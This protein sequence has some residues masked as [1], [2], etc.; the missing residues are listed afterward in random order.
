MRAIHFGFQLH[1]PYQLRDFAEGAECFSAE[2][3]ATANKEV[4]QPL[5]ALL[6]RNTQRYKQFGFSLMVSGTWLELAERY[7]SELIRRLKKLVEL[8]QVELVAMPYYYSLAVF[9]SKDELAEQTRIYREKVQR[10]FGANGR[11]FCLPELMY[12]DQIAHVAEELGFAGMLATSSERTLDWHSPNHV[13][14][15]YGCEY[16]RVLFQN[17]HL[18][19]LITKKSSKI[20]TE[21]KFEDGDK[22]TTREVLSTKKFQKLVDLDCLR[23]NV[24]NLYFDA[25]IFRD[26]R[27]V[28]VVGFFDDLIG[29]WLGGSGNRLV[30][31]AEACTLETPT[32]ELKVSEIVGWRDDE[33]NDNGEKTEVAMEGFLPTLVD[34]QKVEVPGWLDKAPQHEMATALYGMRREILASEDDKLIADFRRLTTADYQF[35]MK[36]KGLENWQKILADLKRR[37]NEAKK[38]QAV[39]I[40]RAWTKKRDRVEVVPP[41]AKKPVEDGAVKVNFGAERTEGV[42]GTSVHGGQVKPV[43]DNAVPVRRLPKLEGAGEK[44]VERPEAPVAKKPGKRGVRRIVKRL[45]LE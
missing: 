43:D 29:N 20:L 17:R 12:S 7:D 16:L 28:G 5:F 30:G 26:L 45:V 35:M 3:F 18:C 6:E 37:A 40:S 27:E 33:A 19:E 25:R 38:S 39:E 13:Y 14:E 1:E 32:A 8:K 9:Y 22:S 36:E 41:V 23:G 34:A 15:A 24:V 42:V 31:A 4:Y 11:I 44:L 21:K 10:L 2:D